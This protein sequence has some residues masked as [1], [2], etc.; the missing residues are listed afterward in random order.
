LTKSGRLD[1]VATRPTRRPY[2]MIGHRAMHWACR[3][4]ACVS[5]WPSVKW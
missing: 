1:T 3:S 5:R 4:V 2:K